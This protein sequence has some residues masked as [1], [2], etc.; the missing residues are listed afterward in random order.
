M[1]GKEFV[2]GLVEDMQQLFARL[3]ETETLE[4]ESEGQVDVVTLLKL[5]LKSE[6]EASELAGFWLPST[7]EVDAK[8]A[9]ALQCGDEMKHYG[10]ISQR[11]AELGCDLSSF[12]PLADGHT[13]LYQYLRGL[14]T[15]VE[16]IAAG[17]FTS[18]AIAEI[19]NT[20]FVNFCRT[21]GDEGTARLYDTVIQPEEIHHHQLGREILEKYATTPELQE[22]TAAAMRN[23]LAIADELRNL[24]EKTTG[25]HNIPVS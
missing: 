8:M 1:N 11:L 10:L 6:L 18:E 5:A 17:V 9:L 20:Q 2:A 15:T 23:T 25:V 24:A 16:R 7:P 14:R 12:D 21:A 22:L 4:S 13:P 3:G 19:R